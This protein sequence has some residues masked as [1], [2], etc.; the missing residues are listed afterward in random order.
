M[1][2]ACSARLGTEMAPQ[3]ETVKKAFATE[4]LI[5]PRVSESS[6][7]AVQASTLI[8]VGPKL[9]QPVTAT[10]KMCTVPA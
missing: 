9:A 6:A 10:L 5:G 7:K 4:P 2:E 1:D 8:G 3:L